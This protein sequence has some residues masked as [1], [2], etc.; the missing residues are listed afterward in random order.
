MYIGVYFG[1]ILYADDIVLLSTSLS[2][3]Q[4]LINICASFAEAMDLKYNCKKCM[5]IRIWLHCKYDSKPLQ[6]CGVKLLVVDPIKYLGIYICSAKC[7]KLAY[8]N[9]E[10]DVSMH[11][12]PKLKGTTIV[13][14]ELL[15][16][17]RISNVLYATEA[18]YLVKTNVK[19]LDKL[20][21]MA[22]HKIC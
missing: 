12:T 2:A 17:Y 7:V 18:V 13:C 1:C 6:L 16:S 20:V 19:P 22:V 8:D 9:C 10:L 3:L 4:T 5:M 14:G 11:F 21:D 15:K